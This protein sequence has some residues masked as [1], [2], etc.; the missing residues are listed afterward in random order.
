LSEER[1]H[2]ED[3]DQSGDPKD[4]ARSVQPLGVSILGWR[5]YRHTS[6]LMDVPLLFPIRLR[7]A[8]VFDCNVMGV[9]L[10]NSLL[11]R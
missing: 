9:S 11:G 2:D 1:K 3:D 5:A 10:D 4:A 6:T 7:D 8:T